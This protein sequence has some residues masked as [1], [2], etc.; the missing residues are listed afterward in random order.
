[1]QEKLRLEFAQARLTHGDGDPDYD[2]ILSLPF[3]D[4]FVREVLR[5]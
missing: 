1:M 2:A 5:M 4:A 3:L